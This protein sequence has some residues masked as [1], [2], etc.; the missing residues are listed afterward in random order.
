MQ[1]HSHNV[2]VIQRAGMHHRVHIQDAAMHMAVC[3]SSTLLLQHA[4][5]ALGPSNNQ[6]QCDDQDSDR[7]S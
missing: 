4:C 3:T 7:C 2:E 6:T 5:A 1:Y